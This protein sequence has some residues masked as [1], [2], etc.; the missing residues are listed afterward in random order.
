M[1]KDTTPTSGAADLPEALRV[2][3][4]SLHADA[5]YLCGRLLNGSLTQEQVVES[6][7]RRI[8]AAKLA[9]ITAQ[10]I[11]A[12]PAEHVQNPAENEHV[13]GDVSKNGVK[14]NISSLAH[15]LFALA[16]RAPGEGIED[17]V[18]R[19]SA[20]LHAQVTALTAAP[21]VQPLSDGQIASACMSYR[22]DFGLLEPGERAKI[23][24]TAR[25]WERAFSKEREWTAPA[26][27]AASS[28][29]LKAIREANMQLVRTGDDAFMLVP[30][31]VATAQAESQPAIRQLDT[32]EV[33]GA[34]QNLYWGKQPLQDAFELGAHW[35][36]RRGVSA[37]K[38]AP[39]IPGDGCEG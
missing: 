2:P 31:K 38:G 36:Y 34:A 19:I 28:A 8:D 7:R 35:G 21:G 17:A 29:V 10:A 27:Q 39:P 4:D 9:A 14:L 33:H 5:G 16:Q 20:T 26:A 18:A 25:E 15:E 12:E 22:H 37:A 23:M 3:L 30:Y 6:I 32:D 24:F 11:S 1:T 13:A